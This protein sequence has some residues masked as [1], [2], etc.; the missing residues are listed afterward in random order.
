MSIFGSTTELFYY[1]FEMKMLV[2]SSGSGYSLL[3]SLEEN[4]S[5]TCIAGEI[6]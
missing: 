5:W 6:F 3:V 4:S 1:R 2:V